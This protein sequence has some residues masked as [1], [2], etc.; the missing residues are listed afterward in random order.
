MERVIKQLPIRTAEQWERTG[1][2]LAY[3]EMYCI[4]FEE[5][6]ACGA[7]LLPSISI[8]KQP[9]IPDTNEMMTTIGALQIE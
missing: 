3:T 5:G 7:R 2:F 9:Y 4:Q 1:G 8:L 6:E